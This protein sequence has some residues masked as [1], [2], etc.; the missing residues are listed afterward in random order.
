MQYLQ[1][2]IDWFNSLNITIDKILLVVFLLFIAGGFFRGLIKG[3][4]KTSF[5]AIVTLVLIIIAFF[6][7]PAIVNF[8]K[9]VDLTS[10]NINIEGQKLTSLKDLP[11]IIESIEPVGDYFKDSNLTGT[12][13]EV[14]FAFFSISIFAALVSIIWSMGWIIITPL[15]H[16][17]FKHF[18]PKTLRKKKLRLLGGVFGAF[19]SLV[20]LSMLLLP[21]SMADIV[22]SEVD[23][24]KHG[25][26]IELAFEIS[27]AYGRSFMGKMMD[28]LGMY[29]APLDEAM[30]TYLTGMN[31]NNKPTSMMKEL[32][33]FARAYNVLVVNDVIVVTG[34]EFSFDQNKLTD[35]VINQFVDTLFE[36]E[37]ANTVLSD[38]LIIAINTIDST[39]EIEIE[40]NDS[41]KEDIITAIKEI[42][43][44][45]NEIK[46]FVNIYKELVDD[47]NQMLEIND[48]L[49]DDDKVDIIATNIGDSAIFKSAFPL[50]FRFLI[51][52]LEDNGV[53]QNV[54]SDQ[55]D[56]SVVAIKEISNYKSEIESL[57]SIYKLVV[58][59]NG[60]MDDIL[61]I[62]E[63]EDKIDTLANTVNNSTIISELVPYLIHAFLS[64]DEYGATFSDLGIDVNS[65][66]VFDDSILWGNELRVIGKVIKELDGFDSDN[67]DGEA[68]S[69]L[70]TNL[71]QS[72]LLAPVL[73]NV[74]ANFVD[75]LIQTITLVIL[76]LMLT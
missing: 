55:I 41:D 15:Y 67:L 36:A 70:F 63:D 57:A 2:F 16:I 40:I 49:S 46:V 50:V 21:Y 26:N 19:R 23:A 25:S 52:A 53:L 29:G 62:F 9:T 37:L 73:P 6:S 71:K 7:T 27:T 38:I 33:Q 1:D 30:L 11:Q 59:E 44:W 72:A 34:D 58:D 74:V 22:I 51:S 35:N 5:S 17:V 61:V 12:I 32:K 3:L 56:E 13:V 20:I 48:I 45:K 60:E 75:K 43:E 8:L 65:I 42:V 4:W 31:V 18:I 68:V 39:D 47:D 76:V 10:F 66:D 24:Q 54:S 14:I 69:G 28:Y 64:N